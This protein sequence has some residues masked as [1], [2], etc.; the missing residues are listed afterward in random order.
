[1]NFNEIIAN[2]ALVRLGEALRLRY[3]ASHRRCE[4]VTNDVYGERGSGDW[5]S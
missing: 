3:P 4:H 1:M 2:I 5:S